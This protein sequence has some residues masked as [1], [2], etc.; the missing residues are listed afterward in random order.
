MKKE[1]HHLICIECPRSCELS[2]HCLGESC[3]VKGHLCPK[4]ETYGIE[5]VLSPKRVLTTTVKVNSALV[6]RL[7]VRTESAIPK[8]LI[9]AC[10]DQVRLIACEVPIKMGEVVLKNLLG[11]GLD[12]IATR[13]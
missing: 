5:E 12:L 13:D 6:P 9:G 2:V 10:M 11:T 7:P 3:D 8:A 4:G 1:V